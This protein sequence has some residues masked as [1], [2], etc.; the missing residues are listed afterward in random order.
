MMD[1]DKL[2]GLP[3]QSQQTLGRGLGVETIDSL[4]GFDPGLFVTQ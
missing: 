1:N 4:A 3:Q 2:E